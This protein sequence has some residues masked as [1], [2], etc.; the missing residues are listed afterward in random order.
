M[1]KL[2][3]NAGLVL[4][5]LAAV[6]AAWWLLKLVPVLVGALAAAVIITGFT[7]VRYKSL[8]SGL[9]MVGLGALFYLYFGGTGGRQLGILIGGVGILLSGWGAFSLRRP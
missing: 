8:A 2:P 3:P 7:P 9:V 4:L 1:R 6:A 5:E